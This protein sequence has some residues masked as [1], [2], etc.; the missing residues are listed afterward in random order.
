M[1]S[2]ISRYLQ[3]PSTVF[4]KLSARVFNHSCRSFTVLEPDSKYIIPPK[5][6]MQVSNIV[7]EYEYRSYQTTIFCTFHIHVHV[8]NSNSSWVCILQQLV[9]LVL[10][11]APQ[12]QLKYS[13]RWVGNVNID[14]IVAFY[15]SSAIRLMGVTLKRS[16]YIKVLTDVYIFGLQLIYTCIGSHPIP[17]IISG[18]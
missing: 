4:N 17:A 9:N 15:P 7:L 5:T 14:V 1:I 18:Q 8:D 12:Y 16:L 10:F 13:L 6:L 3:H 11:F 2:H